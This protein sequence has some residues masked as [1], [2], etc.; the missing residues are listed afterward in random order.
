MSDAYF[1]GSVRTQYIDPV[2]YVQNGRCAF[3]LDG[4]AWC[5]DCSKIIFVDTK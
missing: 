4:D 1:D 3:E 2:S 5:N